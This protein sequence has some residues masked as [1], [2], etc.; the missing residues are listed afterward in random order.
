MG[1]KG[2]KTCAGGGTEPHDDYIGRIFLTQLQALIPSLL[3]SSAYVY[4]PSEINLFTA[5][6]ELAPPH[7]IPSPTP[8]PFLLHFLLCSLP[9]FLFLHPVGFDIRIRSGSC[10]CLGIA[11]RAK[12]LKISARIALFITECRPIASTSTPFP[13]QVRSCLTLLLLLFR[14]SAKS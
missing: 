11:P 4:T 9:H 1:V 6:R 7:S 13:L 8:L 3:R 2:E 14:H 12:M 10:C 5:N